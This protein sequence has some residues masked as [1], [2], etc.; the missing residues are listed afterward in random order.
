MK[1]REWDEAAESRKRDDELTAR[2][3]RREA[4]DACPVCDPNGKVDVGGNRLAD[5]RHSGE[6][7]H[8]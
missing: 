2:R 3:Y 7:R 4:I 1:R 5:C 6:V 8:A